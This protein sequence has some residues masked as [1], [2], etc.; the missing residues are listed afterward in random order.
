MNRQAALYEASQRLADAG[1]PA[2]EARAEAR[3]ILMR[4][5]NL[6]REELILRPELPLTDA[7]R[8]RFEQWLRRRE[9]REPLAYLFGERDFYGLTF[10]VTPA[11][12][13][14][15]PETEL[16]VE[17][18]LT[19]ASTLSHPRIADIGTGSGCVAVALARHLPTATID[20]VDICQEALAVAAANCER[21]GVERQ[22]TLRQGDLLMPLSAK[23][24]Y[25]IIV[26]N[27][28]YIAPSEIEQLE[29]EV[30]DFEPGIALGLSEDALLFHRRLTA[31]SEPL[32]QGILATEVGQGQADEVAALFSDAGFR[33]TAIRKDLAGIGRV[34]VGQKT[35]VNRPFP[36]ASD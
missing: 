6:S 13:I 2:S 33:P 5:A 26:S 1:L 36:F 12:L 24:P 30:R 11:V 27:P 15:R 18:A 25:D 4:A 29:P 16:L 20:A 7:D 21:H 14:P 32:L 19:Y 35:D 17:T 9:R 34:V 23:G 10:L 31:E 3:L 28:P 22:I 8:D